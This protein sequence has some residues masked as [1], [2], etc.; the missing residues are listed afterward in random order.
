MKKALKPEL[1]ED[2]LGYEKY[3]NRKNSS[4]SYKTPFLEKITIFYQY[5]ISHKNK[6]SLKLL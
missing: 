6:N 3:G 2:T 5:T 1:R 4:F